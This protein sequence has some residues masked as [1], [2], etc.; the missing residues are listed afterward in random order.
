M[1]STP[2]P[3]H[4]VDDVCSDL[5]NVFSCCLK[6]LKLATRVLWCDEVA[7]REKVPVAEGLKE[8]VLRSMF[9]SACEI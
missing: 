5:Q 6:L 4:V 1:G 8:S 9:S 3:A 7:T 2:S